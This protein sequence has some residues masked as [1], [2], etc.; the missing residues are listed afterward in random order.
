MLKCFI[1]P[2]SLISVWTL[3]DNALS[4]SQLRNKRLINAVSKVYLRIFIFK[5]VNTPVNPLSV[6]RGRAIN[7][8]LVLEL[9]FFFFNI[10]KL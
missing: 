3:E 7:P 10:K 8:R 9:V 5:N 1:N 4:V 2:E 6:K